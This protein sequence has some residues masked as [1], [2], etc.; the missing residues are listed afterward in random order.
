MKMRKSIP[1][2]G[3]STYKGPVVQPSGFE[4]PRE[5]HTAGH[6]DREGQW[7]K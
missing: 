1:G 4:K 3:N 5:G 6:S 7:Y 2:T